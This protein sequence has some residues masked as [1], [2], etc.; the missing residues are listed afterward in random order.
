MQ[1]GGTPTATDRLLATRYGIQAADMAI[2]GEFGYMAALRGTEMTSVP[3]DEVEGIKT[4][5]LSTWTSRRRS[6]AE[7]RH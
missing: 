4:V 3:L 7:P 5:D 2:A 6:S 1:R